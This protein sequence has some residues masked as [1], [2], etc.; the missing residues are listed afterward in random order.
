MQKKTINI[1]FPNFIELLPSFLVAS[2][3]ED[4][5]LDS[6]SHHIYLVT[7]YLEFLH[8]DVN[9]LDAQKQTKKY[10]IIAE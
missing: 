3:H 5:F 9:I 8:C 6:P 10:Q 4:V 1:W 7:S 2:I